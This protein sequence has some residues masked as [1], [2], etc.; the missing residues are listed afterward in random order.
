[1]LRVRM[2]VWSL[3]VVAGLIIGIHK[4]SASPGAITS[5][6]ITPTPIVQID[7]ATKTW[8]VA[9]TIQVMNGE[10]WDVQGFVI[11][12]TDMTK[13]T[14]DLPSIGTFVDATGTVQADGTWLAT[15]VV[16][17]KSAPTATVTATTTATPLETATATPT[18]VPN[19]ESVTTATPTPTSTSISSLPPA[20]IGNNRE[21]PTDDEENVRSSKMA[22]PKAGPH[23]EKAPPH[24]PHKKPYD[25][26]DKKN[27]GHDDEGDY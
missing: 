19:F 22:P 6:S 27:H 15:S 14:G 18:R 13:I 2:L 11:Q 10:F 4:V 5:A 1:M 17:G 25:P 20:S 3:L 16:V 8:H 26:T 21:V 12:V 24:A 23:N 7:N 9:G